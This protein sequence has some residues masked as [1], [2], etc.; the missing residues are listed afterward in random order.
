MSL[1]A[2]SL[3]SE[4]PH[5]EERELCHYDPDQ[6]KVQ[7]GS[8]QL[9]RHIPWRRILLSKPV[10]AIWL[11]TFNKYWVVSVMTTLQPQ[12]FNDIYGLRAADI[13][14]LLSAQPLVNSVFVMLGGILADKLMYDKIL[15][16]TGTRKMLQALGGY[17]E[18]LSLI[19]VAFTSDW[20]YSYA[21]FL[22]AYAFG[23]LSVNGY[24]VN[25][26]D[27]SSQYANIVAGISLTGSSGGAVS[28]LIASMILGDRSISSWRTIVIVAGSM[29]FACS[30]AYMFMGSGER[31]AWDIERPPSKSVKDKGKSGDHKTDK[32]ED[33]SVKNCLLEESDLSDSSSE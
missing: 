1:T 15:S 29:S 13:G 28:T 25:R 11:G 14:F 6:A 4:C 16:A 9:A 8:D 24:K 31:Q 32:D 18:G 19:A 5:L 17:L 7:S 12:F 20:R 10:W 3:P 2:Y 22:S 30:T 26:V 33:F 23:G 27:L 21:F